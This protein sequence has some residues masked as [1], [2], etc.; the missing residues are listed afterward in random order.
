MS[1]FI[2]LSMFLSVLANGDIVEG[3]ERSTVGKLAIEASRP[4]STLQTEL[5]LKSSSTPLSPT[6]TSK[7]FSHS[8]STSSAHES[9]PVTVIPKSFFEILGL[10]SNLTS[11]L[12]KTSIHTLQVQ[13]LTSILPT[14]HC[15]DDLNKSYEV[16]G[17]E[18]LIMP[19]S[20]HVV[21]FD[22]Y[23]RSNV[24]SHDSI[25]ATSTEL[26]VLHTGYL[27]VTQNL[28]TGEDWRT[29]ENS[30]RSIKSTPGLPFIPLTQS[31]YDLGR[32][33]STYMQTA[34]VQT[35]SNFDIKSGVDLHFS[36]NIYLSGHSLI[37][38]SINLTQ[39]TRSFTHSGSDL[40]QSS[41]NL[42]NSNH[43]LASTQS[44]STANE[45][46]YS[47][48]DP[49]NVV[50][51]NKKESIYPF[52]FTF[53][54]SS[55]SSLIFVMPVIVCVVL[56]IMLF[57][58]FKRWHFYCKLKKYRIRSSNTTESVLS[59][60]LQTASTQ[61]ATST[62]KI[63]HAQTSG[64]LQPKRAASTSKA[65]TSDMLRRYK[66]TLEYVN[67]GFQYSPDC[68]IHGRRT[69]RKTTQAVIEV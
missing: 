25:H 45:E 48:K 1:S 31:M 64:S 54:S 19:S 27:T 20:T 30:V 50:E 29:A 61:Q 14:S 42:T 57:T 2:L 56:A 49:P 18:P 51:S 5:L 26:F 8:S 43:S 7:R 39:A 66:P 16:S 3:E 6:P 10:N 69:S 22:T 47:V 15:L 44:S 68:P 52:S 9:E 38:S 36:S 32:T 12:S 21:T 67:R 59:Q 46:L 55:T 60:T 4:I 41:H 65:I 34:N 58:V 13:P 63:A 11:M 35:T 33:S 17:T 23:S 62:T 28:L 37:H 40:T 53:T 24:R